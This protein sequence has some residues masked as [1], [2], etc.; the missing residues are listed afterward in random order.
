MKILIAT[1]L[2]STSAAFAATVVTPYANPGSDGVAFPYEAHVTF[3]AI[4]SWTTSTSVGGWSYV[5][6]DPAK[7]PNRGWGHASSSY[8]VEIAA[9]TRFELTLSSADPTTRPGFVLYAGESIDDL[10]GRFHTYSNNGNDMATLNGSWDTNATPL[11]YVTHAFNP[12]GESVTGTADLA[13]GRYTLVVGNG[14]D[15]TTNPGGRNLDLTF[16][17]VPEPSIVLLG[18][19]GSLALLRRRR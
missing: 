5:D 4:D 6:L 12:A 13:P 16:T 14:A 2:A 1:L 11:T 3:D 17:T 10:P 15:S 18:A 7:N 9:A 19:L 8:L